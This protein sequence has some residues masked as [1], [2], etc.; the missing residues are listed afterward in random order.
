MLCLNLY[1]KRFELFELT[2]KL[3]GKCVCMRKK[4][5]LKAT[6]HDQRIENPHITTG[7]AIGFLR[8]NF[9]L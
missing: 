9:V 7:L 4:L 3:I 1:V 5:A 2:N 8:P 6:I